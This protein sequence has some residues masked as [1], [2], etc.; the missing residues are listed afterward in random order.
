VEEVLPSAL[1]R[2]RLTDGREVVAAM[3]P[4]LRHA[5]VRLIK[6]HEVKVEISTR[7]PSRAQIIEKL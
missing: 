5:V 7:D 1:F 2:V 6:G 4:T 3:A